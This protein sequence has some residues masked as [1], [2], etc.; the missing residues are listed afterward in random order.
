MKC[1]SVQKKFSAYQDK[2]LKPQEQEEVSKHLL[3]AGP[4]VSSMRSLKGSGKSW[5]GWKKFIPIHGF[6]GKLL[7][8]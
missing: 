4:V 8:K 2:E 1:H 3:A 5:G 6:T 7:E